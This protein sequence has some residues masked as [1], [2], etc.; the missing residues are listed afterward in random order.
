MKTKTRYLA[1]GQTDHKGTLGE[2]PRP[3]YGTWQCPR[4][5]L[6]SKVT[7]VGRLSEVSKV[8]K[9]SKVNI[10]SNVFRVGKE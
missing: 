5:H 4:L 2:G 10:V 9:V 6:V 8:R 7:K 1:V 3:N